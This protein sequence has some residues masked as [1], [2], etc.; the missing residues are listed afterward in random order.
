MIDRWSCVWFFVAV[1]MLMIPLGQ[2]L[3]EDHEVDL[4]GEWMEVREPPVEEPGIISF[5]QQGVEVEGRYIKVN[6]F[7]EQYFGFKKNELIF[8]GTVDGRQLKGSLLVKQRTDFK[9]DCLEVPAAKW[10]PITVEIDAAADRLKGAWENEEINFDS[11]TVVRELN[12]PYMLQR[13]K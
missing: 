13:V 12:E 3:A 6:P 8:K 5:T 4:A 7:L 9:S 2:P 1:L 10:V 11:C